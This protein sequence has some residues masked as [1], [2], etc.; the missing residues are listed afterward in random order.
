MSVYASMFEHSYV[1]IYFHTYTYVY[2]GLYVCMYI[3][4]IEWCLVLCMLALTDIDLNVKRE[5]KLDEN[6]SLYKIWH[7]QI[8]LNDKIIK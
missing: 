1:G 8:I 5:I 2:V 6:M 3:N 7:C 4:C